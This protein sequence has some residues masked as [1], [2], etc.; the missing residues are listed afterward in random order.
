[1]ENKIEKFPATIL[2]RGLINP[3]EKLKKYSDGLASEEI[4][5]GLK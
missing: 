1:M 3:E 2:K 5:K 4:G